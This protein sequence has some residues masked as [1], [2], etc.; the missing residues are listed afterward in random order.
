VL[1]ANPI[2]DSAFKYLLEDNEV[3]RELLSAILD[4]QI[5]S[6]EV[7]PQETTTE[8]AD[9]GVNILRLDFKAV[10]KTA[11]DERRKVLIELQKA[12]RLC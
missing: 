1:I 7:K 11:A 12:K 9:Y 6:I 3:A 8:S 5:V 2:Y 4:E 10:V